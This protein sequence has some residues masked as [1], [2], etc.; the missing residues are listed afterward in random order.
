MVRMS[1]RIRR[2]LIDE[3]LVDEAEWNLS[4]IHI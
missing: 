3:K 4:L 2:I 1:G